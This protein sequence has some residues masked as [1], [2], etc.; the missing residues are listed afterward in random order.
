[1][2]VDGNPEEQL[3]RWFGRV[4]LADRVDNGFGLDNDER[5]TPVW[6][7]GDRLAPWSRIWPEVRHLG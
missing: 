4:E 7:A 6:I 2:I 5:G 3:R 1:M